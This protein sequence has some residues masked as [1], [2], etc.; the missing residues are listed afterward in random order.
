M[1][2]AVV[3]AMRLFPALDML[4]RRCESSCTL[5]Y[6]ASEVQLHPGDLVYVSLQHVHRNPALYAQPNQFRPDHFSEE[7]VSA[8]PRS[9]FLTFGDGPRMCIGECLPPGSYDA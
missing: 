3:E 2:R 1:S 7:E 9:T 5:R 4:S 8:R 6:G